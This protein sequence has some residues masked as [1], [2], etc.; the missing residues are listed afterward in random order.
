MITRYVLAIIAAFITMLPLCSARADVVATDTIGYFSER[1]TG[2]MFLVCNAL[3]G[4]R[5][6]GTLSN[7]SGMPSRITPGAVF[8]PLAPS[9][10][11]RIANHRRTINS[12]LRLSK[13]KTPKA[14]RD[15]ALQ[16]VR[17]A[18]AQLS[19]LLD[20]SRWC[21]SFRPESPDDSPAWWGL[22]KIRPASEVLG[23]DDSSEARTFNCS[24]TVTGSVSSDTTAVVTLGNDNWLKSQEV[25]TGGFSFADVPE[26]TYL[27][28]AE[29][30]G[31][32]FGPG[33]T[34][35]VRRGG[36]CKGISFV[37]KSLMAPG[38]YAYQWRQQDVLRNGRERV[39][40]LQTTTTGK[41]T[42]SSVA[43]AS[44]GSYTISSG[45][46]L[47]LSA[48]YNVTLDSKEL[49]W[50]PEHAQR[51]LIG[52]SGL[53][54][55]FD[56]KRSVW[57]LTNEF[58]N[59]DIE[60]TESDE[61]VKVRV[62]ADAFHYAAS[63]P[64]VA[65]G[66]K[67]DLGSFR[68][69]A[70]ILRFLSKNGRDQAIIRQI[71]MQEFY[72]LVKDSPL[73]AERLAHDTTG[74]KASAFQLFTGEEL[75]EVTSAFATLPRSAPLLGMPVAIVRR[76]NGV[77][78]PSVR[79]SH[80]VIPQSGLRRDKPPTGE[81]YL[82][83]TQT[84]FRLIGDSGQALKKY[85]DQSTLQPSLEPLLLG[86][87]A[88]YAGL[89][90]DRG[91][92][93]ALVND[94]IALGGWTKDGEISGWR[95]ADPT[96]VGLMLPYGGIS[97]NPAG[98]FATSLAQYIAAPQELA[99]RSPARYEFMR[100]NLMRGL[101]YARVF[102]DDLKI[103][104][105]NTR[106]D[107]SLPG[108]VKE[109]S[110]VIQGAPTETK[111][112]RADL[113]LEGT[114]P[115]VSGATVGWMDFALLV[116]NADGSRSEALRVSVQLR[117][118]NPDPTYHASLQLQARMQL[119]NS[120]PKGYYELKQ[121]TLKDGAGN[122]RIQNNDFG[123]G[124]YLDNDLP[125]KKPASLVPGT[126]TLDLIEVEHEGITAP[127]F[128][129]R[130]RVAEVTRLKC[131]WFSVM[132]LRKTIGSFNTFNSLDFTVEGDVVTMILPVT[133]HI[134]SGE[135]GLSS[136]RLDSE[137]QRQHVDFVRGDSSESDA[138]NYMPIVTVTNDD[139]DV[140]KPMVDLNN[141]RVE[142]SPSDPRNPNGETGILITMRSK[143]DLS[144]I[145]SMSFCVRDP[146]D[147]VICNGVYIPSERSI[148]SG[149]TTE[150]VDIKAPMHL[151]AGSVGGTWGLDFI[152]IRDK[153]GNSEMY[154]LSE[155]V[156]IPVKNNS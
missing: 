53:L 118:V 150:W 84:A 18:Q 106:P 14:A 146:L 155:I 13:R 107:L 109:A 103:P 29:R 92:H 90:W 135:Y 97:Y 87:L 10:K 54:R 25:T 3:D 136:L 85:Y 82:E 83:F 125:M 119:S 20:S 78:H 4:Q 124:F 49:T 137:E 75:I 39:T 17:R 56:G 98:D 128:K 111:Y 50:S 21:E 70:A 31:Y 2:N 8:S 48:K 93:Q 9:L 96:Q 68:L 47:A 52:F 34:V 40:P 76:A 22:P 145:A 147:R 122:T 74:E 100:S 61:S 63:E 72:V 1:W 123:F 38:F 134:Q 51:L 104:I 116:D 149:G 42:M 126:T 79:D 143:D 138:D 46:A 95:T 15:K 12:V 117:T 37:G 36:A 44:D 64:T 110:I 142:A 59:K 86:T 19:S 101:T 120:L 99:F 69:S 148:L 153:A 154:R 41:A 58:L 57:I 43:A 55:R 7:S 105:Y 27:L 28:T 71:L 102:R 65:Q 32:S 114:D 156:K 140:T 113:K 66:G 121:L 94:W 130:F 141:I 133:P 80:A 144:G 26:G 11:R 77:P 139:E 132:G 60:F 33:H 108:E 91:P 151:F 5:R 89:V 16:R 23:G 81:V 112:L 131:V 24:T 88:A 45:A 73:E 129:V 115:M 6:L 62:S 67:G 127:A 152:S 35:V 30:A